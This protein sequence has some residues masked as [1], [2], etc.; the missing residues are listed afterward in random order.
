M[1]KKTLSLADYTFQKTTDLFGNDVIMVL[2]NKDKKHIVSIG[3]EHC[4]AMSNDNY[5][6]D[7]NE[8][9]LTY[10]EKYNYL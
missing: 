8:H 6:P 7:D 3:K 5:N 2:R 10:L 9:I 4:K 1:R